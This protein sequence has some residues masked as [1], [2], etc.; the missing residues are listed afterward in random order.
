[1]DSRQ[2]LIAL[3]AALLI[4]APPAPLAA[5]TDGDGLPDEWE[6]A[7]FGDLTTAS[8]T[9]DF[10]GDGTSDL[11]EY[12]AGTS[13]TDPTDSL[14]ASI[15]QNG[16]Q[17]HASVTNRPAS[18]AGYAGLARRYN[19]LSAYVNAP[20]R[21]RPATGVTTATAGSIVLD[22]PLA[23]NAALFLRCAVHLETTPPAPPPAAKRIDGISSN[24]RYTIYYGADFGPA[25][26]ALLAQFD[27]VVLEAG[28]ATCTPA[29]VAEL[30]RR[31]VRHVIGYISIGE[32][33]AF[34]PISAGD[35]TGPVRFAG[36]SIVPGSNGVASYYVDQAWSGAAYLSDGQP[37]VNGGFGSRFVNP[38][39]AWRALLDAQRING[40][41]RSIA[42][43]AQLAGPRASDTDTD[44]AHNFGFD[45]FFLDT[46]D[47]A[48]PYANAAGYY[49]WT[50]PAMRDTVQFIRERYPD[51]IVFAN[52]GLFFFNP[53]LVN[54]TYN[55]RSYDYSIRPFIHALLLESYYLDS[56]AANTG[57]SPYFG[58][59]K[60]NFAPKIIAEANRPDGFTVFALDYQMNRS[61]ALYTQAVNESALQNGWLS[62]LAPNGGLDPIGTYVR[63]NPPAP[64]TAAPVWDS[65][66]SPPFS[67]ND[68]PDRIGIQSTA[69]GA[70]AGE[71]IIHWD[72]ARDQT[73]PVKYHVYRSTDAA[74]TNPQKY[75]NVAF[76]IGDGWAT[77]PTV[78]FANKA[79]ITGLAN[80]I[81]YFRVHAEDSAVPSHEDTNTVTRAITLGTAPDLSNPVTTLTIDGSLADWTDVTAYPTDPDDITGA[82]NPLDWREFRAA[83]NATYFYLAYT[84]DPPAALT[85][86]HNAFLDT[87]RSRATGFRG[88]ADN[89]PIGAD[90]MIQAGTLYHY[91]GGGTDWSWA[92]VGSTAF[93]W[94]ASVAEIGVPWS[95]LGNP[96]ALDLFLYGDNPSAG[97][98]T[99][100]WYPDT[101]PQVGGGGGFFK[102]HR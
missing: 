1:M 36:G 40:V 57:V 72:V 74:F 22:A 24:S 42:G 17:F 12:V 50:A 99:V 43:L 23:P 79:T 7:H 65:T 83:H 51:K 100:D 58:D 5:D 27:V 96:T 60:Y 94:S 9:S 77:D 47:T 29:V 67:P 38:N 53:G 52:R 26:I 33:P 31:G 81:H 95:F 54:P 70:Q 63:D 21:W 19:W 35:G 10:E 97:G 87:D 98:D 86:A 66:G 16:A 6:L 2:S 28:V 101:A 46:L 76:Q 30:Q 92:S 44:R 75:S 45:G 11:A 80:G 49:P 61:P 34:V 4:A 82:Q 55:I 3:L 93:S 20:S 84:T 37:D 25:N 69:P 39:A 71:V 14:T 18:G 15:S 56:N 90:Y 85:I 88:G 91:T 78:A 41:P 48:G 62:Y 64:D 73:P 13:P 102:Y 89:F 59:N 68:V 32:E 8:A